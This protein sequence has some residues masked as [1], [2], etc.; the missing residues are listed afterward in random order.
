MSAYLWGVQENDEEKL[1][2]DGK[3]TCDWLFIW[4]SKD[5]IKARLSDY[6]GLLVG[7]TPFRG[8]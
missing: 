8:V 5:K 2:N 3:T 1:E 6:G 7:D 4:S